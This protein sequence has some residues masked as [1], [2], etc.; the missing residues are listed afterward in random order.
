MTKRK[1]LDL[2]CDI[3]LTSLLS[4]GLAGFL[5]NA[6]SLEVNMKPLWG[7][8]PIFT[9]FCCLCFSVKGGTP[10][11]WGSLLLAGHFLWKGGLA[12]QTEAFLWR[13]SH[14]YDRSFDIGYVI[15]WT[16]DDHIGVPI[17]VFCL[18]LAMVLVCATAWGL[19]RR[20]IW[21]CMILAFP[22]LACCLA[23]DSAPIHLP[24]FCLALF[25]FGS[26]TIGS[27]ARYFQT[28]QVHVIT[29]RSTIA[30]ATALALLLA[31]IPQASFVSKGTSPLL[32]DLISDFRDW[33]DPPSQG[34]GTQSGVNLSYTMKL[35][36]IGPKQEN[37]TSAFS[38]RTNYNGYVYLRGR[39]YEIYDGIS[40]AADPYLQSE[41]KMDEWSYANTKTYQ[42]TLT[43]A[44]D[45]PN[46]QILFLPWHPG[47]RNLTGGVVENTASRLDFTYNFK[48]PLSGS[49]DKL[50]NDRAAKYTAP[51]VI[52][53][54]DKQGI[55]STPYLQLPLTTK[56]QAQVLLA[57]LDSAQDS[58]LQQTVEN[59]ADYVRNSA[60]YS[61]STPQMPQGLS[62]FA[63]WFLN[64]SESGYCVHF[65]SAAVV[66]L[67]AAGIPARFVE[68]YLFYSQAD[69]DM[70][71]AEKRAHA[72][73]E[74]Y[75]PTLGWMIL[76]V[77]PEAGLP[78]PLP[79]I[80]TEP[81]TTV[82]PTTVPPTTV[83]PTTV[84]PT[85]VPPATEPPTT[86]PP[87]T[88]LPSSEPT[89]PS[90]TD[91][92]DKEPADPPA[93]LQKLWG[94]M[95]SLAWCIG[96]V[97]FLMAQWK[98][99]LLWLKKQLNRGDP[100]VQALRR[101]KHCC[102]LS[103]L[104]RQEPPAELRNLAIKAK[105][106]QHTLSPHELAQFDQYRTETIDH[107]KQQNFLLQLVCRIVLAI[108]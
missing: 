80:P 11:A 88:T 16:S 25:A 54:M 58:N 78:D 42:L 62:D 17:T 30:V 6:L 95:V 57:S 108:Y 41:L 87:V 40:W 74:Y 101:W 67:R 94:V 89:V 7:L 20:K 35:T 102:W 55:D 49:W 93:E 44:Q 28:E 8:I 50:V 46:R 21:P 38:V 18:A 81:P 22:L 56:N 34:G 69:T 31:I 103:K 98:L 77:T 48:I 82:P 63:L 64:S 2:L 96:I 68:G 32:Q 26:I 92:G 97:L 14:L 86:V 13:I 5:G 37:H 33:I 59:I 52:D 19:S 99:R 1:A 23:L 75:V 10:M 4:L 91:P 43:Y 72:W 107:L 90:E 36:Q 47:H 39:S 29:L 45:N 70:E 24:Y 9:T 51:E 27:A 65:A 61:L 104:R 53:Y 12:A 76:E 84:P 100:N 73:V 85:T 60:V 71:V 66:L 83:P 3:L 79:D 15:W 105:F 106:S